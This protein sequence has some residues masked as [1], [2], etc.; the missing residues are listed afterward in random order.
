MKCKA[1]FV[2][3][4]IFSDGSVSC[5][6]NPGARSIT[7]NYKLRYINDIQNDILNNT[8]KEYCKNCQ[9]YLEYEHLN[10]ENGLYE[11]SFSISSMCNLICRTCRND[12]LNYNPKIQLTEHIEKFLD[13]YETNKNTVKKIVLMGGETSF[14]IKEIEYILN[15][16]DHSK[17][18]N[19]TIFTN[20]SNKNYNF[21]NMISKYNKNNN[22]RIIISIDETPEISSIIRL[23]NSYNDVMKIIELCRKLKLNT[24]ISS[25]I[26][27]LNISYLNS[28]IDY[29]ISLNVYNNLKDESFIY[30]IPVIDPEY[31]SLKLFKNNILK[32]YKNNLLEIKY[33]YNNKINFDQLIKNIDSCVNNKISE[34]HRE[35]LINLLY[36]ILINFDINHNVNSSILNIEIEELILYKKRR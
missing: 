33:K 9:M 22:I 5:C 16:I 19:L 30:F 23:G 4:N 6:C 20:G 3:T 15:K 34:Y 21:F 13:I 26:S 25:T 31:F 7:N 10:I 1:P 2:I 8:E 29:L 36:G 27:V 18:K 35:H 28:L 17:V 11:I 24:F 14:F 12:K 32:K